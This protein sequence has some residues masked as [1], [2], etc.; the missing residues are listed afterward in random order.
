MPSKERWQHQ[1][2]T[3]IPPSRAGFAGWSGFFGVAIMQEHLKSII[4]VLGRDANQL[5]HH[6]QKL[7]RISP[8]LS[9]DLKADA[10][11]IDDR[12]ASIRRQVDLLE[13]WE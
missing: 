12:A 9:V 5:E 3:S 2:S 11:L 10:Q 8:G 4:E 7:R 1:T 13:H 6:A